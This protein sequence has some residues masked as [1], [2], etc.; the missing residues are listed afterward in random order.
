MFITEAG[1][2]LKYKKNSPI[3]FEQNSGGIVS[4]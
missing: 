4:L 1:V 2:K 3:L